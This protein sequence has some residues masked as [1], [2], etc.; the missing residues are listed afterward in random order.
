MNGV[1]VRFG[2]VKSWPHRPRRFGKEERV[3]K[4]SGRLNLPFGVGIPEVVLGDCGARRIGFGYGGFESVAGCR[5]AWK[6]IGKVRS[7]TSKHLCAP[8]GSSFPEDTH[9]H[10]C[11]PWAQDVFSMGRAIHPLLDDSVGQ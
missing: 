7:H 9:P 1:P 10:V 11:E 5:S 6:G 8:Y 4:R 3:S 2:N